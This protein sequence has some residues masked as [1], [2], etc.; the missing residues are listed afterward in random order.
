MNPL[1]R[2]AKPAPCCAQGAFR[3]VLPIREKRLGPRDQTKAVCQ[4]VLSD[5]GPHIINTPTCDGAFAALSKNAASYWPT[6][7]HELAH[8][9]AHLLN[10]VVGN[11]NWL[12]EGVAVAF[13][14]EMSR[15]LT[16]HPM[17]PSA[18]S[19]YARALALV[20]ELASPPFPAAAT[21]RKSSGSL[22]AATAEGLRLLFPNAV[23]ALLT[24]PSPLNRWL[25]VTSWL[26]IRACAQRRFKV[27]KIR[28]HLLELLSTNH[29]TKVTR[30]N[31]E[32][33]LAG[34]C[35]Q[36]N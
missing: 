27:A 1:I 22:S 23:E 32:L 15:T 35:E 33:Y 13:A 29:G 9:T 7:V 36:L 19:S 8:E 12:E 3:T 31:V 6:V 34:K 16:G 26:A 2:T 30:N 4:P 5:A 18:G 21:I 25:G 14:V 10:P 17:A 11:T 20:T 28:L 24:I